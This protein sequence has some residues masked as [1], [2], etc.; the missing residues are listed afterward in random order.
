MGRCLGGG[1]DVWVSGVVV[2]VVGV[3]VVVTIYSGDLKSDHLKS[4]NI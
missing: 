2:V 3:M 1:G 4:G